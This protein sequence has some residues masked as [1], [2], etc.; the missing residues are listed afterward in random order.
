LL[1]EDDD[2]VR[3]VTSGILRGNGY[4]VLEARNA[5]EALLE[6]ES[7]AGAID[8]MLTD[9]V[10]P[11]LSGPALAKRLSGSRPDMKVLYMSG[12]TDDSIVRHGVLEATMSFL[13]K[14]ITVASLTGKV[15]EV[16]DAPSPAAPSGARRA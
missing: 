2:Q 1:V 13:Q 9:V 7:H 12:Y 16:L 10:M 14:P 11:Q 6:S 15:R 8:L 3:A 5:G 4:E